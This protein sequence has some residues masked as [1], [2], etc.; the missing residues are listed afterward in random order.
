MVLILVV[1]EYEFVEC[2]EKNENE[3][4][5]YVLILVVV[6]YEFVEWIVDDGYSSEYWVL[7]LVVVE[8]EFVVQALDKLNTLSRS[9]LNPCCSGIWIRRATQMGRTPIQIRS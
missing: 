6:E 7:I 8:Y 5:T 1:V 9:S 3:T 4:R 2:Y